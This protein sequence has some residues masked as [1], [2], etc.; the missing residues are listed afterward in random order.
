MLWHYTRQ[1]CNSEGLQLPTI[2]NFVLTHGST[3]GFFDHH[4]LDI[5]AFQETKLL[6]ARLTKEIACLEGFE[7]RSLSMLGA[8]KMHTPHILLSL[9]Y[10]H[11]FGLP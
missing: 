5:A 4:K 10:T 8:K 7:V 1:H 11:A 3:V 9:S 2:P 6:K